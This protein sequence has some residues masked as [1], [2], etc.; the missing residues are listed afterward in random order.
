[1]FGILGCMKLYMVF[2][3]TNNTCNLQPHLF[4]QRNASII[5]FLVTLYVLISLLYYTWINRFKKRTCKI[6]HLTIVSASCTFFFSLNKM[7]EQWVGFLPCHAY[8]WSAGA[9]YTLGIVSTYTI[10]WARQ[11]KMYS[12]KLMAHESKKAIRI[13]SS[14]IICCI[15]VTIGTSTFVFP[16]TYSFK[17]PYYPCEL[18]WDENM[19][20]V[21]V[22]VVSTFMVMS[23]VFQSVLFLLLVYPI[24]KQKSCIAKF[25]V[26]FCSEAKGDVEKLAKRLGICALACIISS[27]IFCVIIFLNASHTASIYWCNLATIDLITNTVAIV[28]SFEDWKKRFFSLFLRSPV[29]KTEEVK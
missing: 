12:D 6:N 27:A 7:A 28:V 22:V 11:R 4:W 2:N 29:P 25:Q 1:M 23:F 16:T 10:L 18:K 3:R 21:R 17:C 5:I 9:I 24:I 13:I 19:H 20:T 8:H 26:L 14:A 15:Y